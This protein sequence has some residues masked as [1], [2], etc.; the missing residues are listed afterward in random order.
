MAE[1]LRIAQKPIAQKSLSFTRS[2]SYNTW[3]INHNAKETPEKKDR[4]ETPILSLY[5]HYCVFFTDVSVGAEYSHSAQNTIQA[6][7]VT[8][9]PAIHTH[10]A[11]ISHERVYSS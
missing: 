3:V 11:L 8:A 5:Y 9:I 10:A 1:T 2:N 4:K 6:P 7:T